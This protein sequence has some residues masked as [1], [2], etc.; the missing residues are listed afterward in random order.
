M[1]IHGHLKQCILDFG[2]IYAFWVFSFERYNGLLGNIDSNK[3][4]SF[5]ITFVKR[6]LELAHTTD[7]IED[8]AQDLDEADGRFLQEIL[9]EPP[10]ATKA[11]RLASLDAFDI[12]DFIH[13]S[14]QIVE[15]IGS[16][17]LP[18]STLPAML[19]SVRMASSHYRLILEYYRNVYGNSATRFDDFVEP[20]EGSTVVQP[21]IKKFTKFKLD[22]HT[23]HSREAQS[24]LGSHVQASYFLRYG[25]EPHAYH[26]QVEYYVT[27]DVQVNGERKKHVFELVNWYHEASVANRF[28][29]PVL[30]YGRRSFGP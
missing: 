19:K 23:F 15:A 21:F 1:H 12:D 9:K 27:H 3:K 25:N 10:T 2:P 8:V 11:H 20:E 26:E 22:G 29:T 18:P 4:G 30:R 17:A 14:T 6:F 7:F 28:E 16:A 13:A 5:E 24:G